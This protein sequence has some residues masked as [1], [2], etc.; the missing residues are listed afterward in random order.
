MTT[1]LV[2]NSG[3]QECL[4]WLSELRTHIFEDVGLIPGSPQWV[5]D[6][7]VT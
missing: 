4:L 6:T 1:F 3:D 5:K 2:Q 7:T